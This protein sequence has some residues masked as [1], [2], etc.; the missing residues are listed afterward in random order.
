MTAPVPYL[1]FPGT[2]RDALEF[3]RDVFGGELTMHTF[4][5][6]SREDGPGEAIAH[7]ILEGPV[8]LFGADVGP[9]EVPLRA[10][11][12]SFALLGAADPATLERWFADLSTGGTIVDPF[13]ERP[14]GA[15]DG[16]VVDRF[17]LQWLI[18]YEA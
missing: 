13:T 12:L 17:G 3:Y 15:H 14:W 7:G 2:A 9:D 18:G 4:A 6:F 1:F 10:D 5:E 11:G 8:S 16:T